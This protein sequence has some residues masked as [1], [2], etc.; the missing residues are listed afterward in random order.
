MFAEKSM[1][2]EKY[3]PWA[4]V[5]GGSEGVGAAFAR[6]LAE[7]D[8]NLVLV[9]RKPEPLAESAARARASGVAVRTASADLSRPLQAL[10][11]IRRITDDLEIGL[12]IY[13]AG[14][15]LGRGNFVD[16]PLELVRKVVDVNVAGQ[17]EFTHHYGGLMKA[18]GRGGIVLVGSLAGYVGS[19]QIA[20]YS[21]AK[22]FS[23]IFRRGRMVRASPVR[24][25]PGASEPEF[26]CHAG[27]GS[28][29]L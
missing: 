5:L 7:H 15:N 4:L 19:P 10:G 13:M 14:A 9:A 3:G 24:G 29:R 23:R 2:A 1:F 12:M 17:M 20:H 25:R 22:A 27:D 18:R 11:E 16:L 6:K 26:H 8:L 28:S 21:A